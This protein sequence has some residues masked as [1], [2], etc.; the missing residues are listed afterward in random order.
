MGGEADQ[1][2]RPTTHEI[3]GRQ[4]VEHSKELEAHVGEQPVRHVV[5]QP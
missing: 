4:C 5:S 3:R 2:S 1:I